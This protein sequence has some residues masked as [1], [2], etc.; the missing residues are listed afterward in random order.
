LNLTCGLQIALILIPYITLFGVVFINEST[1][2]DNPRDQD[3]GRTDQCELYSPNGKNSH[4]V[5]LITVSMNG[6][7]VLKL[8]SRM[9]ADT[10]N[11]ATWLEQPHI[12]LILSKYM[13]SQ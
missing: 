10:S 4:S 13:F 9:A 8:L 12:I 11:I 3:G 2:N 7:D 5:S 1:T 6:V